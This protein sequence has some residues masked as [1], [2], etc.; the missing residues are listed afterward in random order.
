MTDG[1]LITRWD[2]AGPQDPT[3]VVTVD[4][5]APKQVEGIETQIAGYLADFPRGFAVDV[6]EDGSTWTTAWEGET[7]LMAYVAAL[8]MP[9]TVPLRFPLGNR[10][11]QYIRMRQTGADRIYYW[12]IAELKIYGS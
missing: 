1:N 7:A 4:L 10:R 2:T 12:T 11:A 5:G 6:S 9:R 3:N 8:E